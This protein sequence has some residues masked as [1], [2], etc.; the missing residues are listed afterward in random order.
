MNDIDIAYSIIQPYFDAARDIFVRFDS[1]RLSKLSRVKLQVE[2]DAHDADRHFARMRTDGMLLQMAPE[3]VDLPEETLIAITTHELGHAADF[4]YPGC[5][6]WPVGGAGESF[7]VSSDTISRARAWRLLYGRAEASSRTADDDAKPAEN[8]MR[9]WEGRNA[10]QIEW[11]A[12]A[13]A[14]EVTGLKIGYC[15]DCM[16]QCFSGVDR[17]AG[18]R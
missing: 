9:A 3:V 13:I 2:P 8:W 11:A 4:A 16:L 5:W 18:L 1:G 15:G 10:D 6:S 7:W 14:L 17:P 12:D